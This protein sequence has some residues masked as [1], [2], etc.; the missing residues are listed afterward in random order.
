MKPDAMTERNPIVKSIELTAPCDKS[1]KQ[2]DPMIVLYGCCEREGETADYGYRE[3][4][5]DH[6]GKMPFKFPLQGT[7][8]FSEHVFPRG[9]ASGNVSPEI[10]FICE[11]CS[12]IKYNYS[13]D[14]MKTF[15]TVDPDNPHVL[16]FAFPDDWR[17]YLD[18]SSLGD[19]KTVLSLNATFY[20]TFAWREKD[21]ESL[22]I[23]ITI[24]S[25]AQEH[26]SS[27]FKAEDDSVYVPMIS[28]RWA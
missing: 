17:D 13:D 3:I 14:E 2:N 20:I 7:I 8:T 5:P 25:E 1:G 15:F 12:T 18:V 6:N 16:R 24:R 21:E 28:A 10:Y 9:Y 22:M 26:Y 4:R 11:D 19:V 27:Y 23:G